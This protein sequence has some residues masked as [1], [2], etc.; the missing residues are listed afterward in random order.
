MFNNYDQL[1][2][3]NRTTNIALIISSI[4]TISDFLFTLFDRKIMKDSFK[5]LT[6]GD[7]DKNWGLFTD[8]T[9]NA[10]PAR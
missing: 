1:I 8:K 4:N 7:E 2:G 3:F 9:G 10:V 6:V 5:Y